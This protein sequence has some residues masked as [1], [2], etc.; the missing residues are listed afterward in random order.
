MGYKR[1]MKFLK[2]YDFQLMYHPKK[3]SLDAYALSRKSV[4]VL[5]MMIEEK[6]L[7]ESL[8]ILTWE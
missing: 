7:I 3:A 2:D 5:V 1:G 4:Q 6:K 8:D